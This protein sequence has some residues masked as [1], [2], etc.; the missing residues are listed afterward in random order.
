MFSHTSEPYVRQSST[1]EGHVPCP[2]GQWR[3]NKQRY[4][5]RMHNILMVTNFCCST[6]INRC[7]LIDL[8][9][10]TSIWNIFSSAF[11]LLLLSLRRYSIIFEALQILI[12]LGYKLIKTWTEEIIILLI[13]ASNFYKFITPLK[14]FID[15]LKFLRNQIL[16][17]TCLLNIFNNFLC[18]LL[19]QV[20]IDV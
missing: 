15:L 16:E 5:R 14:L 4:N 8:D 7:V 10:N 1:C 13:S 19:Y 3:D 17:N 9:Y 20:P 2:R 11:L 18:T 6:P 12:F